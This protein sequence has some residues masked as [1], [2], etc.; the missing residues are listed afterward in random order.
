MYCVHFILLL[1]LKN[2][3]KNNVMSMVNGCGV[4]CKLHGHI[5]NRDKFTLKKGFASLFNGSTNVF[6]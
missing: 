4:T 5:I 3:A 2:V 6:A 1:T